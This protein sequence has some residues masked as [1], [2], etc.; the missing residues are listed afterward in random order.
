LVSSSFQHIVSTFSFVAWRNLPHASPHAFFWNMGC[1]HSSA[2]LSQLPDSAFEL[3]G[4]Q[5]S[6][7]KEGDHGETTYVDSLGGTWAIDATKERVQIGNQCGDASNKI[8]T[9][10][11]EGKEVRCGPLT[12]KV[13]VGF[14]IDN[15]FKTTPKSCKVGLWDERTNSFQAESTITVVATAEGKLSADTAAKIGTLLSSGRGTVMWKYFLP[16]VRVLAKTAIA[17]QKYDWVS[18]VVLGAHVQGFLD[19][20][21]LDDDQADLEGDVQASVGSDGLRA[22][23][24]LGYARAV[25]GKAIVTEGTSDGGFAFNV[26]DWADKPLAHMFKFLDKTWRNKTQNNS[27][28]WTAQYI[29]VKRKESDEDTIK[30]RAMM[31]P[32]IVVVGRMGVGKSKFL[33]AFAAGKKDNYGGELFGS[34]IAKSAGG[35]ESMDSVTKDVVSKT[36]QL[37]YQNDQRAYILTDVPGFGDPLVHGDAKTIQVLLMHLQKREYQTV[38][39]VVLV[40][41]FNESRFSMQQI[42]FLEEMERAFGDQLW[43]TLMIV[44]THFP[45]PQVD[46]EKS[47]AV[48]CQTMVD[49][50]KIAWRSTLG[51][52]FAGARRKL[53]G[54]KN[55]LFCV[56]SQALCTNI[57]ALDAT[58]EIGG[59]M[60]K[61]KAKS[62]KKCLEFSTRQLDAMKLHLQTRTL[63]SLCMRMVQTQ[64]PQQPEGSV[65]QSDDMTAATAAAAA[66]AA[67]D[68]LRALKRDDSS[69]SSSSTRISRHGLTPADLESL[70]SNLWEDVRDSAERGWSGVVAGA[71]QKWG[72]VTA[73]LSVAS[74]GNQGDDRRAQGANFEGRGTLH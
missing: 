49:E 47:A 38:H 12:F 15:N 57:D 16:S 52:H 37:D 24:S 29:T 17:E 23:A 44:L 5:A 6:L 43:D 60:E 54:N 10:N 27:R 26:S 42:S 34:G 69:S 48:R 28:L 25:G 41:K 45:Y 31:N 66:A 18:G 51:S 58:V 53:A 33:N 65:L 73:L 20:E 39:A 21:N 74:A 36:V 30:R 7:W 2:W 19:V 67:K 62:E 14:T 9:G 32:H 56:D 13:P 3:I 72:D 63:D 35:A 8:K 70:E 46:D 55:M 1:K 50:K 22:A 11:D 71:Q 59:D 4:C 64:E 61:G 40:E 68:A